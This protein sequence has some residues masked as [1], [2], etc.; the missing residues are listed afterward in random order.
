MAIASGLSSAHG[1]GAIGRAEQRLQQAMA[2]ADTGVSDLFLAVCVL[3]RDN[4]QVFSRSRE[5]VA[6]PAAPG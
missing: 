2:A 6:F 1:E 3:L 4:G 5:A